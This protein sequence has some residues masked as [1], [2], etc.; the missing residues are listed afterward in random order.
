MSNM[1]IIITKFF[2]PLLVG[3]DIHNIAIVSSEIPLISGLPKFNNSFLISILD[4]MGAHIQVALSVY[5][6]KL[7]LH[8]PTNEGRKRFGITI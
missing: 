2:Q 8:D 1:L 7:K 6:S 5:L 4:P 3:D